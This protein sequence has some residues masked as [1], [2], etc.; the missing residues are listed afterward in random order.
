MMKM[1][2]FASWF[3]GLLLTFFLTLLIV[4]FG[5]SRY[6]ARVSQT[7]FVVP[8][9]LVEIPFGS[10]LKRVSEILTEAHVLE[11][12]KEFAWYARLGRRDGAKIQA[13][14]YVFSGELTFKA[15]ADR[16]QTGLDQ[17]FRVTFKEGQSLVD[18]VKTLVDHQLIDERQFVE[19][20]TSKEIIDLINA[21]SR[22][23]S[24]LLNDVGGIEGYL[25]PDTYFFSK[26]DG[27]VGI[28][29]KMHARLL[30]KLDA[31]IWDRIAELKTDL[32]SVLTLASIIEKETGNPTER[33]IIA[34][35]YQNRLRIG[36]PLQADPTVIYGIKDYDGKI[37]KVDLLT[38]H[39]Y[40][41]YKI[42]G[43]PPG[44]ISSVGIEAIRAALWPADTKY[45]YFVSKND[46]SHLFCENLDC[47]NKAVRLWQIE[48]FK[49]VN[50]SR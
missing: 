20:M 13:G 37:R 46:G 34:S 12:P 27:A 16:L 49:K 8:E 1:R 45:L 17:S 36:M 19:A 48:F 23:R 10:S 6:F 3:L 4:G 15:V 22:A 14:Y 11:E 35:V 43:L 40:N 26:K 32:H 18:L 33:A 21:P 28:I 30:S 44:P 42:K 29:K 9:T 2:V 50:A 5:V 47:H 24:A 7:T 39:P 25:F 31:A 41:T 38:Y